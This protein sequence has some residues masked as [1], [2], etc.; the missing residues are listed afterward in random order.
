MSDPCFIQAG[1]EK[2][3]ATLVEECGEVLAAAGKTQRWGRD[4][5]NP[6]LPK[7]Q[8][9]TNE[10]WLK[11]ELADLKG[12]I[13]RLET[14]METDAPRVVERVT[15]TW[16]GGTGGDCDDSSQ[17]CDECDGTGKVT[18]AAL[19]PTQEAVASNM[20]RCSRCGR[21]ADVELPGESIFCVFCGHQHAFIPTQEG[22]SP[23]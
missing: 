20:P 2:Q 16:C 23:P 22:Q 9:E 19:T 11:R 17:D 5:V 3:L 21:N 7:D 8:Q 1:F 13:Q 10:V 4:S 18:R 15:C 6:L 14:T 12:A